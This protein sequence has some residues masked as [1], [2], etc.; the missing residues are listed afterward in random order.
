VHVTARSPNLLLHVD[1]HDLQCANQA[2]VRR[3]HDVWGVKWRGDKPHF[4][5]LAC[6]PRSAMPP[7]VDALDALDAELSRL[8]TIEAKLDA[9][10]RWSGPGEAGTVPSV[11]LSSDG[12][13]GGAQDARPSKAVT[14]AF[15]T[16]LSRHGVTP[17]MYQNH[18]MQGDLGLSK[19]IL[20][21][22]PCA[23]VVAGR[24]WKC[25]GEGKLTCSSCRLVRYCSKVR[26][27]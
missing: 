14:K 13:T 25:A 11:L 9:I 16:L 5:V 8:S 15:S 19:H 18:A 20:D 4:V 1:G 12:K 6:P 3:P 21:M 2:R 17:Q 10:S 26:P 7:V 27:R 23:H 22:L 24:G